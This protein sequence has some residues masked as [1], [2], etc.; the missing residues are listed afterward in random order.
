MRAN[1]SDRA[2]QC[3]LVGRARVDC[4]RVAMARTPRAQ[5]CLSS[6]GAWVEITELMVVGVAFCLFLIYILV[7]I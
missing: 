1:M 6:L 3:V 5:G 7:Y 2:S 4:V